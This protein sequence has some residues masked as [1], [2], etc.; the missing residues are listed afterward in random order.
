MA[1][2]RA[3]D[4]SAAYWLS[5]T[6]VKIIVIFS[7]VVIR[8]FSV[9]EI[10]IKHS[11]LYNKI[12][13]YFD[14]NSSTVKLRFSTLKT[15]PGSSN[16]LSKVPFRSQLRNHLIDCLS[17]K[18]GAIVGLEEVG[19]SQYAQPCTSSEAPKGKKKSGIEV[20]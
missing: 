7:R 3:S 19:S 10:P 15:S 12:V 5:Q 4:V 16:F 13:Y 18:N 9:V 11:S 14:L 2:N 20:M 8:V 17:S 6:H 1:L